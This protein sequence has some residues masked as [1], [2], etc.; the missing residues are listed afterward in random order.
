MNSTK[1]D[2]LIPTGLIALSIVPAIAGVVRLAELARRAEITPATTGSS[3][4]S[5]GDRGVVAAAEGDM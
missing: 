3:R 4:Y 2:W 5:P 1:S